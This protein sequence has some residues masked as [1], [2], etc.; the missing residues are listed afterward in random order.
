[1]AINYFAGMLGGASLTTPDVRPKDWGSTAVV[2]FPD[3]KAKLAVLMQKLPK[4]VV[5]DYEHKDFEKR[6]GDFAYTV[7]GAIGDTTTTTIVIDAPGT[8]PAKTLKAGDVL[9]NETTNEQYY[10]TQDPVSPYTSI[11]VTR[12]AFGSTAANIGDDQILR[13]IGTAYGAG[14]NAP[15]ANFREPEV[16]TNYLQI[17]KETAE[18][19]GSTLATETRPWN[20]LKAELQAQALE[21]MLINMEL[22]LLFGTGAATTDAM[23][24]RLSTMKGCNEL[25]T[26]NRFDYTTTGNIGLTDF[27]DD[28]QSLFKY[29]SGTKV[30]ICGN[31]C[32]AVLNR[33]ASRNSLMSYTANDVPRDQT[34]GLKFTEW[35]SPFGTLM[36]IPS[37]L[38]SESA[39][40]TSWGFALDMKYLKYAHLKGRDLKFMADKQEPDM[41]GW[42]G[43]FLAEIGLKLTMEEVHGVFMGLTNY[44]P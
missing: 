8:Y 5:V 14:T 35:H 12:G 27:E 43:Y 42:K 3:I 23:G 20:N 44:V 1:M 10:V 38:L 41:D 34:W 6:L 17:F 2:L 29:G 39:A 16:V 4:K 24:K 19:D 33:M 15:T 26:T 31:T 28:L 13:K 37:P 40:W 18:I 21:R 22:A 30:M 36:L 32:F 25:I 7:N 9:H 11:V